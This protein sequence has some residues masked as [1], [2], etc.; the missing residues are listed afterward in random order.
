MK[1]ILAMTFVLFMSACDGQEYIDCAS[2]CKI[3]GLQMKECTHLDSSSQQK[4][5]KCGDPLAK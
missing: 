5:C 4:S 2:A 1:K 3:S